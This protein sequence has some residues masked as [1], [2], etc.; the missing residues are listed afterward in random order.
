MCTIAGVMKQYKIII[1]LLIVIFI[2]KRTLIVSQINLVNIKWI[3]S[4]KFVRLPTKFLSM[5]TFAQNG[6]R[7]IEN[8]FFF[9]TH[10]KSR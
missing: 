1:Y 2:M 4:F 8:Q 3:G 9:Q 7:N 6:H 5:Y 10:L